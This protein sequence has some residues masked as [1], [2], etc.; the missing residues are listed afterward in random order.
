MRV[1]VLGGYGQIGSAIVRTLSDAGCDV[2]G[3]GRAAALGRRLAPQAHWIGADIATLLTAELWAPLLVDVEVVV[4][5]SG[6]L[7]D[8][9]KDNLSRV[10]GEAIAALIVACQ[11]AGVKRFVQ[12]SAPGAASDART[13]FLRTKGEADAAL[14]ASALDWIIFKPGL[15]IGPNAYGGTAL[16]RMLAAFPLVQPIVLGDAQVQTVALSDVADAV[17]RGALG[18]APARRDYDLVEENPQRLDALI[19]SV[20]AW[21]GFA[22]A[23][24][25]IALP[26]W[27]GFAI[28]RIAD[29]AGWLG[30]RSPLRTTSLRV[31]ADGVVG[32]PAPWRAVTGAPLQSLSQTLAAM[33]ATMQERVFARAQLVFPV[34][35]VTLALFWIA[36]GVIGA[37]QLD[38]SASVLPRHLDAPT[39][40][41]L[42][43]AGAGADVAI[44]VGVL[45]RPWTR[46][47]AWAAVALSVAYLIAAS[48]LTPHLW[49]DP[50][51]PLVKVFPGIGLALAVAALAEK[52]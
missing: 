17:R 47:A 19:A 10:Q 48:L 15:V 23:H 42:V 52:R 24:A 2:V 3:L 21:A 7:Q 4:N 41:A 45:V 46:A 13:A 44:G 34:L 50:L 6:A 36:S 27:G 18:Q 31:L 5:A 51:G 28:A 29:A 14:R 1:L 43:L 33:L 30:W 35:V 32:D 39:R 22:P 40:R 26:R 49:A 16:V 12:I 9:A 11:A 20:R 8:G 38:A 37:L 25:R